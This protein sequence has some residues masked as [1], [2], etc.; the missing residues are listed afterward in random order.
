M[1]LVFDTETTGKPI[2]YDA[3][4]TDVDNWPRLVQIAW[5]RAGKELL[6]DSLRRVATI[7]PEGF[8]IPPAAAAIHGI[9]TEHAL[10]HGE[11]IAEVLADFGNALLSAD[12]IVG[13]NLSF[14]VPIVAAEMVR[15]GRRPWAAELVTKPRYDTMLVGTD[16]CQI[17]GHRG[18]KWPKLAELY[19]HLFR[20]RP[21][22]QHQADGDVLATAECYFELV[23]RGYGKSP[24]G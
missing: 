21:E 15:L 10:E 22:N 19:L 20:R 3:S 7:R 13:H 11:P 4:H 2:D 18:Y 8:E 17:P 5:L 1:I 9:S 24:R 12:L 6:P 16:V 23:G 14:D